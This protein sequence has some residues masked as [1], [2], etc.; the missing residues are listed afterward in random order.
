METPD[1][2][3]FS[4][5]L[6]WVTSLPNQNIN[7]NDFNSFKRIVNLVRSKSI[8]PLSNTFEECIDMLVNQM[9]IRSIFGSELIFEISYGIVMLTSDFSKTMTKEQHVI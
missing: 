9:E 8:P 7:I 1:T 5:V 4:L 3:A 2:S 6:Q